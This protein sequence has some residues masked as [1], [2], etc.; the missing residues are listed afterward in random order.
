MYLPQGIVTYLYGTPQTRGVYLSLF[1]DDTCIYAT[2]RK[3][4][5]VFRKLQRDLSAIET[6]CE[7]WN[8]KIN[9]DKTQAIYFSHSAYETRFSS[10]LEIFQGS[11]RAMIS[12]RLSTFRIYTII[13]QNYAGKKQ[14][15][16]KFVRMNMLAVKDKAKPAVENIRGGGQAY[17]RLSD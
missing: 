15:S 16:Y 9:E 8:I 10:P 1:A 13:K 17:D 6:W 2:H 14:M 4:G 12:T 3:E 7:R 5:Y 11:H